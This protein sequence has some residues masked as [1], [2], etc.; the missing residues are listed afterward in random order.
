[1]RTSPGADAQ[2]RDPTSIFLPTICDPPKQCKQNMDV[3]CHSNVVE[4]ST[5]S[6][7]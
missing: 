7:Q 3:R 5:N 4:Q 2:A 1:M 6:S